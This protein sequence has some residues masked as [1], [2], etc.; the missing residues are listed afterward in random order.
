MTEP[1]AARSMIGELIGRVLD[2]MSEP[3]RAVAITVLVIVGG[4]GY[5]VWTERERLFFK[6][7]PAVAA[8]DYDKM[9]GELTELL[10]QTGADIDMIWSI[11]LAQNAQYFVLARTKGGSPWNFTPRRLPAIL[12]ETSAPNLTATLYG[13]VCAVPADMP[14]LLTQRLAADGYRRACAI[15]IRGGSHILG[16]VY[17]AWRNPPAAALEHAALADAQDTA[18]SVI[19]GQ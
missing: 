10:H 8:L 4:I 1:P 17:F 6:P 2:Y 7:P 5:G 3:W 12:N 13:G 16:I 14:S 11:Q 19:K 9:P 15:A 18:K